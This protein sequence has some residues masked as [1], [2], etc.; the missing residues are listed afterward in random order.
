MQKVRVFLNT[1]ASQGQS[2]DWQSLIQRQLFRS[3]LDF[4]APRDEHELRAEINRATADKVDVIVSVG[5]DGTFH[6]LIQQLAE[7]ETR[8]LVLPAGT[9]ND[10]ARELGIHNRI[11]EALEF[12]RLDEWKAIDLITVNGT[13]MATNGGI[14]IIGDVAES[15]NQWRRSI[16]G[17]Q[18]LMSNIGHP[19]YTLILGLKLLGAPQKKYRLRIT[20]PDYRGELES[21]LLMINNQPS[22][23]GSFKIAPETKNDDGKFN[24]SIFTHHHLCQLLTG[25]YR[26]RQHIP[27]TNDPRMLSFETDRLE[28]ELLDK[29][30]QKMAFYGDGELLT[31]ARRLEIGIKPQSLR[32]YS[33]QL[34][35][36]NAF[37]ASKRLEVPT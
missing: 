14:G 36:L 37:E 3:E 16:P 17:F 19:M 23:A 22:V 30:D 5:G 2:R 33:H 21:P 9:A 25:I 31:S 35:C 6:T 13:H 7:Q 24:V 28:L 10:L 1:R 12:V 34:S 32:V 4:I 11:K 26:V 20:S 8:F 15:I 27:P 18:S 29:T